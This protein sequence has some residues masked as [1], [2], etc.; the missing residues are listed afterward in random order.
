MKIVDLYLRKLLSIVALVVTG[1]VSLWYLA[2]FVYRAPFPAEQLSEWTSSTNKLIPVVP[3]S[4]HLYISKDSEGLSHQLMASLQ[5]TT[6]KSPRSKVSL[7]V[8]PVFYLH[9]FDSKE[10]ENVLVANFTSD[11][12]T[13]PNCVLKIRI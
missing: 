10:A 7:Q 2:T 12:K 1:F 8:N 13:R 6:F 9:P 3:V 11:G 5:G 4:F